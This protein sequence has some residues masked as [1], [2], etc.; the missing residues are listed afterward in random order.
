MNIIKYKANTPVWAA[1]LSEGTESSSAETMS[2]WKPI[3]ITA[4]AGGITYAL[5]A[6]RSR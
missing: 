6:V 5:Y 3:A 2:F 4:A 1:S